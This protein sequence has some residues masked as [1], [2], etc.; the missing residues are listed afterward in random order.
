MSV[1]GQRLALVTGATS[2]IGLAVAR[3]L[4]QQGHRVFLV[5]AQRAE[6]VDMTV[7]QLRDE[8]LDVDGTTCDVRSADEI[9]AFVAGGRRPLRACRRPGEQRGTQW[10]RSHRGH[11]RRALVRR[12]RHQPQQRLPDDQGGPEHRRD[13][14]REPRADHQHRLHRRQA[15]R[16]AR[17]PVLGL[18]ARRRR[19]HQGA[20]QRARPDRHH[21]Q[22]RLPR[23]RRDADG[24]A[25]AAGLRGGLGDHRG[26]DPA[27]SSRPR[28]RWAATPRRRRWPGWSA[29][30]PPTPPHP[31]P[32]RRSTSAADWATSRA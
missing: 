14:E 20:G 12:H 13:A 27:R 2:G 3:T 5:R 18:Q 32:P 1:E 15:G 26:R 11:R 29:T 17:R 19:L 9:N 30:W 16:R 4:A 8:G 21:R 6:G 31:S 28:S 22:R 10:R 23:I 7:K 25:C 24:P